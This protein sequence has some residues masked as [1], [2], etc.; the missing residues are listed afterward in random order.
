MALESAPQNP[1]G[2]IDPSSLIGRPD[3]V[4]TPNAVEMLSNA[5][6]QGVITA[7][8]IT[9]RI[10]QEP[11]MREKANLETMLAREG[12]TPEA[13]ALRQKGQA[14]TSQQLDLQQAQLKYGPAIQYFQTIAPEAGIPVPTDAKGNP[15]YAKMAEVGAKLFAWKTKKQTAME[16]LQ[17]V[18]WK[19]GTS[20]TGEKVLLKFNKAGRLI[21]PELEQ[22]L[23]SDVIAPFADVTPGSVA[24]APAAAP[25]APAQPATPPVFNQPAVSQA[26]AVSRDQ[27]LSKFLPTMV[28]PKAG[29]SA[30]P[31]V[32]PASPAG[33][34]TISPAPVG[35]KI[36]GV[37]LSLGASKKPEIPMGQGA[38]ELAALQAD[39]QSVTQL[40]D[41][42]SN[43]KLNVVGP[44]AGS[45]LVRSANQVAAALGLREKEFE[46]QDKLLQGINKKVLDG[47]QKMKGNLSDKDIKFLKESYPTLTSTEAVWTNFLNNWDKMIDL[48][49]QILRGTAPKGASIFEQARSNTPGPTGNTG[50]VGTT[51]V[52]MTG[53]V[54]NLPGRG[55][56]RRGSDGQYY[57]AQ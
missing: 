33:A 8:D 32:S 51:G 40:K 11:A 4:V 36:P 56:V 41:I 18:E 2:R 28:E 23:G 29:V 9:A 16:Q 21:T 35:K 15:D 46:S 27:Q 24:A 45:W 37:G 42:I 39:K 10:Q 22:Q 6:R 17:P 31:V 54:I 13:Q 43:S 20:D 44:G 12:Q 49:E 57:P 47:A 1:L 30:P 25:A 34:P 50:P 38:N 55:P 5:V 14:V 48:N 7:S 3:P 53:P 26:E 19:E 52:Q